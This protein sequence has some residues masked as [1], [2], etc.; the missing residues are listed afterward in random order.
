M[1]RGH[2][3]HL[4]GEA[5]Q[6]PSSMAQQA[7]SGRGRLDTEKVAPVEQLEAGERGGWKS[8]QLGQQT[9]LAHR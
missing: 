1:Q 6:A 2:G 8:R 5:E 9:P 4:R 7:G 3:A